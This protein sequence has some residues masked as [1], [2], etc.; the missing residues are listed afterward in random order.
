MTF[1]NFLN[2]IKEIVVRPSDAFDKLAKDKNLSDYAKVLVLLIIAIDILSFLIARTRVDNPFVLYSHLI[3]VPSLI[4]ES[5]LVNWLG[6]KYTNNG[7]FLSFFVAAAFITLVL[8]PLSIA[9]EIFESLIISVLVTILGI[10]LDIL[11]ISVIYR[12][13]KWRAVNVLI[14]SFLLMG[15]LILLI[16]ALSVVLFLV[17]RNVQS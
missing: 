14:R 10:Y 12:I 5:F 3:G 1:K 8:L 7:S 13:T 16:L 11:A 17:I 4:V 15:G 2:Y 9:L 6:K